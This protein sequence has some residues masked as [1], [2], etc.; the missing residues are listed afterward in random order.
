MMVWIELYTGRGVVRFTTVE[1]I[2]SY[3]YSLLWWQTERLFASVGLYK[4]PCSP[5]LNTESFFLYLPG[6]M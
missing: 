2:P 6:G 4:R 5:S 1:I 3:K